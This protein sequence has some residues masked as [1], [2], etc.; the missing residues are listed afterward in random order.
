MKLYINIFPQVFEKYY[1]H[2]VRLNDSTFCNR[3]YRGMFLFVF[4]MFTDQFPSL[5]DLYIS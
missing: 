2:F 3:I 4:Q 1:V 5:F